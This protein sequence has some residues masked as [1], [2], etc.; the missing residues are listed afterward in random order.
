MVVS[1]ATDQEWFTAGTGT[2]ETVSTSTRPSV[3]TIQL[4]REKTYRDLIQAAGTTTDNS[5]Q[6]MRSKELEVAERW[7]RGYVDGKHIPYGLTEDEKID[8]VCKFNNMPIGVHSPN[9]DG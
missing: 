9:K 7:G 4:A 6:D 5:S 1:F 3:G 2:D 8:F